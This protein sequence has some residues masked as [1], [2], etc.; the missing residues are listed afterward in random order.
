M[1]STVHRRKCMYHI[2]GLVKYKPKKPNFNINVHIQNW[3]KYALYF[4]VYNLF[5]FVCIWRN[6]R[7]KWQ[8]SDAGRLEICLENKQ[9][10][11][12]NLQTIK[13]NKVT[14]YYFIFFGTIFSQSKYDNSAPK[15]LLTF[16]QTWDFCQHSKGFFHAKILIHNYFVTLP[17]QLN[18]VVIGVLQCLSAR[19]PSNLNFLALCSFNK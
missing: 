4:L 6:T 3:F 7:K 9:V 17:G 8:N 18:Q 14:W 11:I 13:K 10:R 1:C 19:L 12:C 2:V 15:D 5:C 16:P